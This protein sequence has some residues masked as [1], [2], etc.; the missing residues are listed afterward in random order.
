MPD[1]ISNTE[2]IVYTRKDE[3]VRTSR[4]HVRIIGPGDSDEEAFKKVID[5]ALSHQ[6]KYKFK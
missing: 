4:S 6:R 3:K 5:L 2:N 1:Q